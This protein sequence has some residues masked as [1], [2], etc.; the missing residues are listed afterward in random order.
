M[1]R[2]RIFEEKSSFLKGKFSAFSVKNKLNAQGKEAAAMVNGFLGSHEHSLDSKNRL[3]IPSKFRDG[4]GEDFVVF[5]PLRG[6][7]LRILSAEEW[8]KHLASLRTLPREYLE[9]IFNYYGLFAISLSPDAQG[10]VVIPPTILQA[11]DIDKDEAKDVVILGCTDYV[12]IW[13]RDKFKDKVAKRNIGDL[14]AQLE[15]LGL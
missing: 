1:R 3:F 7:C 9:E 10:R 6:D 11:A 15:K 4:L 5:K 12:E 2:K 13:N 8:Q 14:R